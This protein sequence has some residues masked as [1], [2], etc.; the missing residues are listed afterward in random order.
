MALK[1]MVQA[2]NEALDIALE[3]DENIVLFGE[4][5]GKNGGVFRVSDGLQ[6]KYGED[7]VF[8][9]PLAESAIGGLAIGLTVEAFRP[10][11]EIQFAGFLYEVMDALA[12]QMNRY[13]YR[14]SSVQS[15][16]ITVRVPFGG[17]VHTPE[18]H[19]DSLEGLL[20]QTPGLIVV[21][22]SN[23][24]DAK[25]LLLAAIESNDPVIF[26]EH[27]KLYRSIKDEVPEGHYTVALGKANV[28]RDGKD[29]SI[30]TYGAMVHEAIAAAKDLEKEG[31]SVEIIDL[32]TLS[33][34]DIDTILA[35]VK[36]TGRVIVAQEAQRQAGVSANVVA[37]ISERAVLYLKA[38]IGRIHAPDTIYPFGMAEKE[39]LPNYNDIVN[40]VKEIMHFEY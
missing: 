22:P 39:W 30:I 9:T 27:M 8:D 24:I 36:K 26:F 5:V 34:L 11:M 15:M 35:S 16:P 14:L 3:K 17:G 29:I 13:R 28:V 25:G 40:K 18:M 38:P 31:I 7:R 32:R 19:A 4:D 1:T 2:I 37:E 6:A 33:P 21:V 23:P 12:G 20:T 10:I